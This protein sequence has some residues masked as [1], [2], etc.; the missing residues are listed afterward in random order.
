MLQLP[1][2]IVKNAKTRC[3]GLSLGMFVFALGGNLTYV[4]SIVV[5]STSRKHLVANASWLA[6]KCSLVFFWASLHTLPFERLKYSDIPPY[7]KRVD[8]VLRLCGEF[9]LTLSRSSEDRRLNAREQVLYQ[10]FH[11]RTR[12]AAE[13]T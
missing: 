5:A 13:H 6:G 7:R 1:L 3:A 10:F 11:Y 12:A 2:L 9:Y 8:D 4:L